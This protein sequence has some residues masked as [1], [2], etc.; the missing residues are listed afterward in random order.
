MKFYNDG[1]VNF[2]FLSDGMWFLT[3]HKRWG[4][5]KEDPDYLAVAQEGEPDR[6]LQGGRGAGQGTACRRTPMRT[7]EADRRR[8]VGR[9]G[10]E[11]ATPRRS[12]S[13]W[14][15]S[16]SIDERRRTLTSIASQATCSRRARRRDADQRRRGGERCRCRIGARRNAARAA[17]SRVDVAHAQRRDACV[18][19]ASRHGFSASRVFIATLG[20]ASRKVSAQLPIPA[21]T[22]EVG[23]RGLQRSRSTARAERPGHRLE[24]A[25]SRCSASASASASRRWSASRSASCS[26]ASASCPTWRRRSSACC[27]R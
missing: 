7:V 9:Q 6:D 27:G 1:Y 14:P 4:L 16:A 8:R 18:L 23:G 10:P 24:R 3:Q 17:A 5:L 26:G 2:P 21:T 11:D 15:E 25:R 12:R 13:R 19:R 20:A 22:L